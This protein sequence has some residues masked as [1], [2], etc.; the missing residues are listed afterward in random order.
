MKLD[1]TPS[2]SQAEIDAI[3]ARARRERALAVR[4]T[5]RAAVQWLAHPGLHLHPQPRHA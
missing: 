1:L 2:P 3:I 4:A 5:L